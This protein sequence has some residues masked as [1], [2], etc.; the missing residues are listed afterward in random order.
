MDPILIVSIVVVVL[1]VVTL[2]RSVKVIPQAQAAVIE[3]LGRFNKASGAGL[4]WLVP[5]CAAYPIVPILAGVAAGMFVN[6]A[7]SRR[8]VFRVQP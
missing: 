5:F 6:F 8:V 2:I 7:M 4:V 3:R 1:V